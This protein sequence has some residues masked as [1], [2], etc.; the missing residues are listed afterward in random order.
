M[1]QVVTT[2]QLRTASRTSRYGLSKLCIIRPISVRDCRR[3]RLYSWPRWCITVPSAY[4]WY[5]PTLSQSIGL[6]GTG[7]LFSSSG[8]QQP[9]VALSLTV[10]PQVGVS[11]L[12]RSRHAP[13]SRLWRP[14]RRRDGRGLASSFFVWASRCYSYCQPTTCYCRKFRKSSCLFWPHFD[15]KDSRDF[16]HSST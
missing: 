16:S 14:L 8:N 12:S 7:L 1:A 11:Y 3:L 5:G 10:A 6:A 15:N 9:S 4:P 2:V 13:R